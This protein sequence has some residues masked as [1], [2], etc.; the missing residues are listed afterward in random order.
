MDNDNMEMTA[1]NEGNE[2]SVEMTTGAETS[3]VPRTAW[4]W[5]PEEI[6]FLASQKAA[7]LSRQQCIEAYQAK[8]DNGRTE[9]SI[10]LKVPT[11]A[12]TASAPTRPANYPKPV[13]KK[14]AP[15]AE[16][17]QP[18]FAVGT[19]SMYPGAESHGPNELRHAL[20]EF[21]QL[22]QS[23]NGYRQLL[24]GKDLECFQA[25]TAPLL[26]VLAK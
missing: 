17:Y 25:T 7:G 22:F 8:Y 19:S 1:G 15:V 2:G 10:G 12:R 6:Q 13:A 4:R 23:V 21:N 24:K 9:A 14:P 20:N 26:S 5:T 16:V 18:A 11:N 3:Q